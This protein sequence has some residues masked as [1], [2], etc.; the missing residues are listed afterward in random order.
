MLLT[1]KL[2]S[3]CNISLLY[4]LYFKHF[5]EIMPSLN[6]RPLLKIDDHVAFVPYIC[7][8]LFFA[9]K[10]TDLY[11]TVPI[12]AL[13][14]DRWTVGYVQKL[15]LRVAQY[16]AIEWQRPIIYVSFYYRSFINQFGQVFS[17]CS[18]PSIL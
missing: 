18:L 14:N 12:Y 1:E 8:E 6:E 5:N 9:N 17:V 7:S 2:P 13:C 3:W 15:M 10:P 4:D 16:K 11:P